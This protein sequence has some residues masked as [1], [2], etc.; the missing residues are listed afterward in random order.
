MKLFVGISIIGIFVLLLLSY[1]D[2]GMT[3][4]L[5]RHIKTGEIIAQCK[6]VP[7]TNLFSYSMPD[8]QFINHHWL[9][10]VIFFSLYFWGSLKLLL[11]FKVLS[12]IVALGIVFMIAY[13][14]AGIWVATVITIPYIFVLSERFYTRPELISFVLLAVFLWCI[15][16]FKVTG[17]I[18]YLMPLPMLQII[19]V[20]SHIYFLIGVGLL[21]LL[22][23]EYVFFKK[24]AAWNVVLLTGITALLCLAN[25]NGLQ[26]ALYPLH[27]LNGYGY[28]IIENQNIFFLNTFFFNPR[29]LF[30]E[31]LTLFVIVLIILQRKKLDFF[32]TAAVGFATIAGFFMVRNFSIA[33]LITIPYAAFLFSQVSKK[34]SLQQKKILWGVSGS[35]IGG[36]VL[37]SIIVR[38]GSSLPYFQY[39]RGAE[40]AV[41]FYKKVQI[42][43][44]FF[45]NFDIGSYLI[46][47]LY[48][49]ERVFV[50][51]R[52]EAYTMH[53]FDEYK[54]MQEDPAFFRQQV[55]RYHIRAIFFAHTDITPWAQHFLATIFNNPD[56]VPVYIDDKMIILV[57]NT[58]ENAAIIK[59]YQ[60]KRD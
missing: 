18:T 26:G 12:V 3:Q 53:F 24:K 22:S 5:G 45:N 59:Q 41:E 56:W 52:P 19:W 58:P 11:L 54:R 14:K 20:N 32:W 36:I 16:R 29:I 4:D 9:S 40:N 17:K 2:L 37:I 33:A 35:M 27:I 13:R 28:S 21:V 31:L 7:K 60:I 1:P 55:Q 49:Q 15:D 25:P 30:F 42:K 47:S 6:C 43:G 51:G 46:Y 57:S 10:E 44:P 50:D 38:L 34:Y 48:P 23:A 8:Q 39:E